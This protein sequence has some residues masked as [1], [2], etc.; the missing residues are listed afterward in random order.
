MAHA[1]IAKF[2]Q[3]KAGGGSVLGPRPEELKITIELL[4][5][6]LICNIGGVPL[7]NTF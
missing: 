2:I 3:F 4:F 7:I 6:Q 1:F 5:K